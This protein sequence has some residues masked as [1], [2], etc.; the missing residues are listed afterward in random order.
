MKR[1]ETC[2]SPALFE[3]RTLQNDYIAVVVDIF[4]ATTCFCTALFHGAKAIIP[5]TD[6]VV[7]EEMKKRGYITAAERG[8]KKVSFVDFGNDPNAFI[9]KSIVGKEIAYST[10]NGTVAI[11]KVVQS[12]CHNII[13]ASFLN[14]SAIVAYLMQQQ[15]NVLILCSGWENQFSFEDTF[16][17]G[18]LSEKLLESSK[19]ETKDDAT[20]TALTLWKSGKNYPIEIIEKNSS[21]LHRLLNFGIT[22]TLPYA[23]QEDI[24]P[25]VPIYKNQKISC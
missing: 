3:Y 13:I 6:L 17:A 1:I 22:N 8:G 9:T 7:L 18:A 20:K 19:F 25:I 16:F 11:D 10:T 2:F 21:H 14:I 4:R 15:Q 5:V 23:L 12:G 24:C